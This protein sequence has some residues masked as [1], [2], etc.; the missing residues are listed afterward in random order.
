MK[1]RCVVVVGVEVVSSTFAAVGVG[2]A[3]CESCRVT[4][5]GDRSGILM[6]DAVCCG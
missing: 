2:E 6:D 3:A 1:F 4:H 5:S